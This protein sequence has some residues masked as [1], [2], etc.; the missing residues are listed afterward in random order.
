MKNGFDSIESGIDVPRAPLI[1]EPIPFS[2][3][4]LTGD[5]KDKKKYQPPTISFEEQKQIIG[6]NNKLLNAATARRMLLWCIIA[7]GLLY[8]ADFFIARA[9]YS[10]ELTMPFFETM[11]FLVTSLI[12][13]SFATGDLF[14]K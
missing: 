4:T 9:G 1:A 7:L 2:Q 3:S 12:G 14:S 5:D 8:I 10:S 11:R 6:A 13:Y